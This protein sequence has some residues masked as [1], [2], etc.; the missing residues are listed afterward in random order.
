MDSANYLLYYKLTMKKT[1]LLAL[2]LFAGSSLFAQK[3]IIDSATAK[4]S[5]IGQKLSITPD[6]GTISIK[7]NRVTIAANAEGVEY[8][9][10]GYFNGRIVVYTKNT[11]LKLAGAY[12]ENTDGEPAVFCEAKTEISTTDGT[13]NY[14]VSS[15]K[16]SA[17]GK[18]GALQGKKNLV[19]GGSG[20]LYVDGSTYHGIK[21]DD[22]KIKGSGTLYVQGTAKGS[23]L[24]CTSLTVEK[25]KTFKAYFI[26]SKN[27]IKADNTITISSGEFFLYNNGT[28]FKTD[29]QQEAP[30]EKHGIALYGGLIHTF[31][32]GELHSTDKKAF[33]VRGAK[34][35]GE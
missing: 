27:G 5:Y 30:K 31:G 20:T 8:T 11:V 29:T 12:L 3:I 28:A 26:N 6:D 7:N 32:N 18:Y 35:I 34:I 4:S 21:A 22:V 15:G 9:I 1:I 25:D 23:G 10:S 24:N 16:G 13:I 19:L 17:D 2:A 14:I 33:L